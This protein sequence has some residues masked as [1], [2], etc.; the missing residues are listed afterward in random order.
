MTLKRVLAS[1]TTFRGKTERRVLRRPF[2]CTASRRLDL[3]LRAEEGV[4][5][6]LNATRHEAG[7]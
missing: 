7:R 5:D 3:I 4:R 6:L 2:T 1:L